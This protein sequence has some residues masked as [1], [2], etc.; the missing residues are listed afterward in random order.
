M[1]IS[2]LIVTICLI[3]VSATAS[4]YTYARDTVYGWQLMT[5]QEREEHRAKMRSLKTEQEREAYRIEHHKRMQE[6]AKQKGITLP[7][8][9]QP[10]GKG[11]RGPAGGGGQGMG[12]GAGKNR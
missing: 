8:D 9:P 12:G 5:Q 6:R 7:D 10:M 11:M 4:N 3:L 1:R 2:T